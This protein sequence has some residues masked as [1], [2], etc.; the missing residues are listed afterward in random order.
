VWVDPPF[1][2]VADTTGGLTAV[3]FD[4]TSF[5]QTGHLDNLGWVEAVWSDGTTHYAAA[6]G[7]GLYVIGLGGDGSLSVVASNTSISE[8]RHGWV[9]NGTIYEPSGPAGLYAVHFD[10]TS[11]TPV[12]TPAPTMAWAQGTWARG[13]RVLFADATYFRVL[14]FDGATF[15]DVITPDDRHPGA[16]RIWSDGTRMFVAHGGGV[17]AF[18]LDGTTLTELDTFATTN[19][20]ARDVWSDGRRV[21]VATEA[22]GAYALDFINDRFSLLDQVIPSTMAL[23]IM[24]D[25]RYIFVNDSTGLHA[26]AGF[27]CLRW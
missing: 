13:N 22:E 19:G 26:Y 12:G 17:T 21:F 4:G 15:T 10:G 5:T 23:G 25:G 14:D 1:V 2:L 27:A 6:P 9:A 7:A 20:A 8:A 3:R 18:R 24:G 11:L 16:S